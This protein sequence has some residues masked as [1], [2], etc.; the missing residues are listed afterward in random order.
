MGI[1]LLIPILLNCG[2]RGMSMRLQRLRINIKLFARHIALNPSSDLYEQSGNSSFETAWNIIDS[3]FDILRDFNRGIATVF[4]NT[5]SVE[6]DFSIL[7]WEKNAFRLSIT[8]LSL[9]SILQCKQYEIL[10]DLRILKM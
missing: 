8:Y 4:A 9:E 3:R 6:S 5:A 1:M 10:S 7:G 2:I